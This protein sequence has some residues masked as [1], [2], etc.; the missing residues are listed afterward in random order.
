MESFES[1]GVM[2]LNKIQVGLGVVDQGGKFFGVCIWEK[3]GRRLGC[4]VVGEGGGQ[5]FMEEGGG[6]IEMLQDVVN[7]RERG[8]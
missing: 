1:V 4:E 3:A 7:M 6:E 2:L 5:D 8:I